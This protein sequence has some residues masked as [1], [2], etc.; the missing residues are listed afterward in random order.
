[1]PTEL[2]IPDGFG[3][4]TLTWR[5]AGKANPM[6]V[7]SGYSTP[8]PGSAPSDH[9]DAI[10]EYWT[11]TGAYCDADYMGS[12]VTFEGV[13]VK[14][15]DSGVM[16]SGASSGPPVTGPT[17]LAFPPVNC[18]ILVQKRT[19]EVGRSKRGRLYVPNTAIVESQVDAMGNIASSDWD[20]LQSLIGVM[21]DA[22]VGSAICP[23]AILHSNILEAPTSVTSLLPVQ[24]MKTQRRRMRR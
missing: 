12:T 3:M 21:S 5:M 1:M 24:Q 6:T 14:Y 20:L 15:N 13:E 11:T 22:W 23:P 19:A 7:T 2:I 8:T 10:Y 4:A 9:A 17:L 18:C 16:L